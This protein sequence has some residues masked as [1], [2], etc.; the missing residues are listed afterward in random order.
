MPERD[1]ASAPCT[2]RQASLTASGTVPPSC[3]CNPGTRWWVQIKPRREA[4]L[5]ALK[6]HTHMLRH[7]KS[8]KP[9]SHRLTRGFRTTPS[10]QSDWTFHHFF[11]LF[12]QT[13]IRA[14]GQSP[15]A[16]S[17]DTQQL[18]PPLVPL[19]SELLERMSIFFP[20]F[21]NVYLKDV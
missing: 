21:A 17:T 4:M 16:T 2:E 7:T 1:A 19:N 15:A 14:A 12:K 20:L 11:P 10:I 3:S 13:M 6:A 5:A 8:Y 18:C 9:V